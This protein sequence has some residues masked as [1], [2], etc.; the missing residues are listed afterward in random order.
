MKSFA[1]IPSQLMSKD[2]SLEL[3]LKDQHY[4]ML[5]PKGLIEKLGIFS[6][7]LDFKIILEKSKKLTLIGP[8]ISNLS[9]SDSVNNHK[10]GI[11]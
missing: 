3:K 11:L 9:K 7:E 10:E 6:D 2:Q 1:K 8:N 5:I 4:I